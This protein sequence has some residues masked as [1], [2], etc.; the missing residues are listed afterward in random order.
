MVFGILS[1]INTIRDEWNSNTIWPFRLKFMILFD[2]EISAIVFFSQSFYQLSAVS[3][4]YRKI[5]FIRRAE[6]RRHKHSDT[7]TS[8]SIRY[9]Q[10]RLFFHAFVIWCVYSCYTGRHAGSM[11]RLISTAF[12]CNILLQIVKFK[13]MTERVR[14]GPNAS[15][16]MCRAKLNKVRL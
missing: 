4:C 12:T 13:S 6:N 5:H 16:L 8:S 7:A 11:K 10:L 3:S 9:P 14:P 2:R 15:P 1:L